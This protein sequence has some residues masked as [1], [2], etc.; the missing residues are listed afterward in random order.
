MRENF[1]KIV[2]I[3]VKVIPEDGV[4]Q[5]IKRYADVHGDSVDVAYGVV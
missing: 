5:C 3:L 1:P 2:E 4:L